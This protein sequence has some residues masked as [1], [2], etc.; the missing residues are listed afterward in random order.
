MF[1]STKANDDTLS[2]YSN[3]KVLSRVCEALETLVNEAKAADVACVAA[4]THSAYL[5]ALVGVVLDEPLIQSSVRKI[6]NGSVTVIDVPKDLRSRALGPKPKLLGGLLSRKPEDFSL[7]IPVCKA[8]R[9]N[10]VRHLPL[11]KI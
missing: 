10:E 6:R 7:S 4:V 9:I 1:D 11:D 3:I 5:R 2:L 8:V